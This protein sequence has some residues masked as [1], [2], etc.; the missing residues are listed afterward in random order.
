MNIYDSRHQALNYYPLLLLKMPYFICSKMHSFFCIKS[1]KSGCFIT[2]GILDLVKSVLSPFCPHMPSSHKS[3]RRKEASLLLQLCIKRK[4]G[5]L[6]L[7][8]RSSP[9]A[10]TSLKSVKMQNLRPCPRLS[11]LV[12]SDPQ[13]HAYTFKFVSYDTP[14]TRGDSTCSGKEARWLMFN[15][16]TLFA[17]SFHHCGY[18]NA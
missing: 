18:V 4:K 13:W 2:D 11:E 6:Q 12:S 14:H 5:V 17:G 9:E 16:M 8:M 10:L 15:E 1:L 7:Q 3:T